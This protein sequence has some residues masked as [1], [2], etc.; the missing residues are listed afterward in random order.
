VGVTRAA[1]NDHRGRGFLASLP[2]IQRAGIVSS[3]A[4]GCLLVAGSA[5]GLA[6]QLGSRP[7]PAGLPARASRIPMPS[8]EQTSS[9]VSASET[10][11]AASVAASAL[12]GQSGTAGAPNVVRAARIAFERGDGTVWVAG[13]DGSG[14]RSVAVSADGVFS[15]SPDGLTLALVDSASGQLTLVTVATGAAVTVG[16]AA[17]WVPAWAP[18]S[19]W[20][21]FRQ[22]TAAGSELMRVAR[23]GAPQV[24]LGA[25]GSPSV[26]P[27]GAWVFAVRVVSGQPR[28]VRIPSRG[29]AAE[30]VTKSRP[31]TGV[32]EVAVGGSRV[33]FAR[34]AAG[35]SA[36]QIG[37][38]SLAG[39]GMT[40]LIGKPASTTD[41]SFTSLH[42]SPD[43]AWLAYQESGDDGYSHLY[44]VRV[45]DR[46]VV[47]LWMRFDAYAMGWSADGTELLFAEGNTID[48]AP[49]EP[50]RVVA[51]R[52]DG[53][54]R[55]TVAEDAGL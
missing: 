1:G 47:A 2:A 54:D 6:M 53:T 9:S 21:V 33:F 11:S 13:E 48:S 22:D 19:T 17:Q 10:T 43:G 40:T 32:S 35:G 23:E 24:L 3:I 7:T 12:A 29:G 41:V 52:P 8:S 37:M 26:A 31:V 44:C 30:D 49:D 16:P 34:A 51:V 38:I 36:P 39:S 25:G 28:V 42:P 18:D 46:K 50:R 14:A 27:D 55:H 4:V 15:L 5:T 20:L 45:S